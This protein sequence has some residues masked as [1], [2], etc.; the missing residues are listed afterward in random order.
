MRLSQLFAVALLALIAPAMGY[1]HSW[2]PTWSSPNCKCIK[3]AN[4]VCMTLSRRGMP[5]YS[6]GDGTQFQF[7]PT[8]VD[9]CLPGSTLTNGPDVQTEKELARCYVNWDRLKR[10]NPQWSDPNWTP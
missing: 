5:A 4:G 6:R 7:L 1:D 10:L 3:N 9:D 8:C 2:L